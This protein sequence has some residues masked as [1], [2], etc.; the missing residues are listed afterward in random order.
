MTCKLGTLVVIEWSCA[1]WR[2][3]IFGDSK[4]RNDGIFFT[5]STPHRVA[6]TNMAQLRQG[7]L[8]YHGWG[9]VNYLRT[10]PPTPIPLLTVNAQDVGN[11]SATIYENHTTC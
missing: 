3:C 1:G 9:R 7:T 5:T 10:Y 8:R 11:R 2:R 6:M 4:K